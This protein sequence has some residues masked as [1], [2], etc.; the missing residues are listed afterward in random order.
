[1]YSS[2][3]DKK[4]DI[5][6][7]IEDEFDPHKLYDLKVATF[8]WKEEYQDNGAWDADKKQIGFIA[9]DVHDAY[10]VGAIHDTTGKTID[11]S[12]RTIIPAMLALIQEQNERIKVLERRIECLNESR[13]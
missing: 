4:T 7:D 8:R 10:Y 1:M 5:S 13:K 2:S 9:E 11:W 6:Y 12:H 3:R